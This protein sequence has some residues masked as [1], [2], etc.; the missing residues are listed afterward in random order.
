MTDSERDDAIRK[1]GERFEKLDRTLF[2]IGAIVAAVGAVAALFGVRAELAKTAF[3]QQLTDIR[4]QISDNKSE[5]NNV[6]VKIDEANKK[7]ADLQ[8]RLNGTAPQV[9]EK[10]KQAKL[11]KLNDEI[12]SL[13]NRASNEPS[14]NS[15][16]SYV[17]EIT[18][19][20]VQFIDIV[21]DDRELDPH[22]DV[23]VNLQ[24]TINTVANGGAFTKDNDTSYR[25][26]THDA[27]IGFAR[28]LDLFQNNRLE[29]T[30]KPGIASCVRDNLGYWSETLD[31]KTPKSKANTD[32]C[33][34]LGIAWDKVLPGSPPS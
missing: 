24:K 21:G 5:L 25:W 33:R 4:K 29:P 27:P 11:S 7:A 18:N 8:R 6:S 1:L 19:L 3:D 20:A 31:G 23:F 30:P 12:T 2:K 32:Y 28:L 14:S 34:G 17:A 22:S 15:Y 10:E 26:H 16:A 9:I 13:Q